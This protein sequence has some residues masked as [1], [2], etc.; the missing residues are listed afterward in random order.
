METRRNH[1]AQLPLVLAT[2][3]VM[4]VVP[5]A[6]L[7]GLQLARGT[8]FPLPAT[9]VLGAGLSWIVSR[10]GLR[11]WVRNPRSADMLFSDLTL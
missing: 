8:A 4:L 1:F 5:A 6:L 7:I 10:I 11:L 3:T 9:A 2:T